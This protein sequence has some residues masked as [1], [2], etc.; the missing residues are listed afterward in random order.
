MIFTTSQWR[1]DAS[2]DGLRYW[3]KFYEQFGLK[4]RPHPDRNGEN[5]RNMEIGCTFLNHLI[6]FGAINGNRDRAI[7]IF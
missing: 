1:F 4:P 6:L 5:R 7:S 2:H 3:R